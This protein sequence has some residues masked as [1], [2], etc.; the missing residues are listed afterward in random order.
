MTNKK[1]STLSNIGIFLLIVF[2]G[3][4]MYL[5]RLSNHSFDNG[6]ISSI[7]KASFNSKVS[8]R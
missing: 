4:L 2:L 8:I 6:E 3:S 5:S 1:K 7:S